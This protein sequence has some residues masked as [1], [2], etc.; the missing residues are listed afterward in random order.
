M[1]L[2]LGMLETA[3]QMLVKE[4]N[5]KTQNI[6][7]KKVDST[8]LEDQS[9]QMLLFD[10]EEELD[11]LQSTLTKE[12]KFYPVAPLQ[13]INISKSNFAELEYG[14]LMSLYDQVSSRWI[15]ANNIKTIEHLY[16]TIS[17]L[18]DLWVKD[19]NSFFEELWF[20]LKTNLATTSLNIIFNDLKEPTEKQKEKGAKNELCLSYVEGEKVPQLMPGKDKEKHL[21]QEYESDFSD[22]FS[23]TDYSQERGQ[24]VACAKIGLSPVLIMANLPSFNQLQKSI[25]IALF[26]GLQEG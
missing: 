8:G 24:F 3:N 25:L 23:I 14:Q 6:D 7:I 2:R 15:L 9:L 22:F 16:P 1:L 21:M 12:Q 5:L 19:R 26:T 18:K 10:N 17:Y 11:G 20:I 4:I 13:S